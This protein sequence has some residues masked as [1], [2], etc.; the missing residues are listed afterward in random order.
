[1]AMTTKDL[2][3]VVAK[4]RGRAI[5]IST[6]STMHAYSA[7]DTGPF[8][9]SSVPLMGGVTGLGLGL[10]VACPQRPVILLDGDASLLMQ[11][12]SLVS[13]ADAMPANLHHFL[14]NNCVNFAGIRNLPVAGAGRV[15]FAAMALAAGYVRATRI[16]SAEELDKRLPLLLAT[17]GPSFVDLATQPEPPRVTGLASHYEIPDRQFTRM[18][19]ELLALKSALAVAT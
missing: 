16:D 15:D 10:A 19:D 2:C 17:H 4:H 7:F 5:V 12:G 9:V 18:G 3:G 1:M 13:V 11:L 14:I 6:M 8:H